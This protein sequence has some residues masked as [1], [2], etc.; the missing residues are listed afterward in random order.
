MKKLLVIVVVIFVLAAAAY[1]GWRY[2][3]PSNGRPGETPAPTGS[4]L[5]SGASAALRPLS[6]EGIAGY[7]V[8]RQNSTVYYMTNKGEIFRILLGGEA[9]PVSDQPIEN[10]FSLTPSPDGLNA[11]VA[12]GSR[13]EP[14]FTVFSAAR[15]SWQPLP[16]GTKAAAWDPEGTRLALIAETNGRSALYV[17]SLA[18][19]KL[20]E[21]MPLALED[22][23]LSWPRQ[24]ELYFADRPSI[25]HFGSLW[26]LNVTAKTLRRV[27]RDEPG[28]MVQWS[29]NGGNALKFSAPERAWMLAVI[30]SLG[31]IQARFTLGVTIPDKCFAADPLFYCAVPQQSSPRD[32]WPDGYLKRAFYT[33]D[34]LFLWDAE[35]NRLT[36][37]F[38]ASQ[39][40]IDATMLTAFQ[41][42]L[43]F[44]NRY[45]DRLYE[46]A[47]PANLETPLNE[48]S[49]GATGGE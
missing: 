45:D 24:D 31:R 38:N 44:V 20:T 49:P 42:K 41:D 9:Q 35:T 43:F 16:P 30:D 12:F 28:L 22:V 6:P 25:E 15:P 33:E 13:N 37:L 14:F 47:L 19:Q 32:V 48:N 18:D 2:F 34:S 36:E 27:I 17:F 5:P 46:L 11:L 23:R 1:F 3:A 40:T 26:L 7:W 29:E 4:P 10:V 8:S 21:V 39:G